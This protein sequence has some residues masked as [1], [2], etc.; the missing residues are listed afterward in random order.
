MANMGVHASLPEEQVQSKFSP[1]EPHK[2]QGWSDA[3]TL[4]KLDHMV[5]LQPGSRVM[6]WGSHDRH[7]LQHFSEQVGPHGRMVCVETEPLALDLLKI[8]LQC[9]ASRLSCTVTPLFYCERYSYVLPKHLDCILLF[10]AWNVLTSNGTVGTLNLLPHLLQCLSRR[11]QIIMV[12]V[13]KGERDMDM[14]YLRHQYLKEL[15]RLCPEGTPIQV[16][17]LGSFALI[18]QVQRP[19]KPVAQINGKSESI[20]D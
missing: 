7:L 1:V 14:D 11:G 12:D 16:D 5:T 15:H 17:M 10:D 4:Q 19:T 2:A 8:R 3:E 9:L 13:N 20:V 6:I 18:V